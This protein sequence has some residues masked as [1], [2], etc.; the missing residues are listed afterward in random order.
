MEEMELC[1]T[2]P[3]IGAKVFKVG[4]SKYM[5][6]VINEVDKSVREIEVEGNTYESL[7]YALDV[8]EKEIID[9]K[10]GKK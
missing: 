6:S 2:Y 10:G 5:I 8:V 4:G 3:Q 9:S 7:R 1:A